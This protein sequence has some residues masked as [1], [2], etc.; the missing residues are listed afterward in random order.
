MKNDLFKT[1]S[2][3]IKDL[4]IDSGM[5]KVDDSHVVAWATKV[6]KVQDSTVRASFEETTKISTYFGQL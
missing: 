4:V 5:S 3:G 2:G 6:G 1:S